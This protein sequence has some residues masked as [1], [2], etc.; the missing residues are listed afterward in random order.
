MSELICA[1]PPEILKPSFDIDR[2]AVQRSRKW[3]DRKV[4]R[5]SFLDGDHELQLY[6][7]REATGLRGWN[8]CSALQ[9]VFTDDPDAEIRI[10][11]QPG[12]S[13]SQLGT[14]A[15]YVRR[16]Q[17]TCNL[18]IKLADAGPHI[19]RT[20]HHELGHAEAFVHGHQVPDIGEL[21]L[22]AVFAWYRERNYTDSWIES[23]V[24]W[25]YSRDDIEG[26]GKRNKSVMNYWMTGELWKNGVGM[27]AIAYPTYWDGLAASTIYGLP[28][29]PLTHVYVP[30]VTR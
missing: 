25:R 3:V 1:N 20:I 12:P 22:P 23:N 24:I 19:D 2:T 5:V 29:N 4:L 10:T 11:F 28:P 7:A 26:V 27:E 14:D 15:L 6:V 18:N 17:P 9:L 8:Y 16:G 13:W 21:D 30:S